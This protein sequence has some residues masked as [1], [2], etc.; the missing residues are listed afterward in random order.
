[1]PKAVLNS[2]GM[3]VAASKR[4]ALP[5][6]VLAACLERIDGVLYVTFDYIR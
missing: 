5:R 6:C 4:K 3:S 2:A 1:M